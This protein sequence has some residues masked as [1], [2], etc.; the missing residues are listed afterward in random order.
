MPGPPVCPACGREFG[1]GEVVRGD[2]RCPGCHAKL[3]PDDKRNMP[4]WLVALVL[5]GVACYAWQVQG[6]TWV[7]LTFALSVP[8]GVAL[9]SVISL[10]FGVPL[11]VRE[12]AAG[13]HL[14]TLREPT[15]PAEEDSK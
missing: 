11:V 12:A 2:I 15:P 8:L 9:G 14:I 6:L 1:K 4:T 10:I 3:K 13:D 5:S 7:A